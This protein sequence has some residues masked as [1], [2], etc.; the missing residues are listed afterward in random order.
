MWTCSYTGLRVMVAAATLYIRSPLFGYRNAHYYQYHR[1]NSSNNNGDGK[2]SR[3]SHTQFTLDDINHS[4][5]SDSSALLC[6][7]YPT[8]SKSNRPIFYQF[9]TIR[10]AFPSFPFRPLPFGE[11]LYGMH[12]V[13]VVIQQQGRE[14]RTLP[15][16]GV[17]DVTCIPASALGEN[18]ATPAL[19]PR[20]AYTRSVLVKC[21]SFCY[22]CHIQ[23][24]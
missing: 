9:L 1:N 22:R 5:W 3:R 2:C 20:V 10:M 23:K 16:N 19:I 21:S 12:E 7:A 6:V 17:F 13:Q 8:L 15:Y 11:F 24:M 14:L 18:G 4:S